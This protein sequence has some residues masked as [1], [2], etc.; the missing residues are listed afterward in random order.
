M[1][2]WPRRAPLFFAIA[3]VV[4]LSRVYAGAHY[5]GDVLSGA[6]LGVT[7]AGAIRTAARALLSRWRPA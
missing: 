6:L 4:G 2:R 7:L 1:P 3:S 5:P